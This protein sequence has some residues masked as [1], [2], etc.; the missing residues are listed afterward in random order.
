VRIEGIEDEIESEVFSTKKTKLW[1]K[2]FMTITK[3]LIVKT[4]EVIPSKTLKVDRKLIGKNKN[5]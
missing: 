2:I 3:Y 1:E 4:M 5:Y